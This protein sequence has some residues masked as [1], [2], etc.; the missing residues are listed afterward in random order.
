MSLVKA[1]S[2][3]SFVSEV[4]EE[5]HTSCA[6]L[7]EHVCAMIEEY[8]RRRVE[9]VRCEMRQECDIQI[10]QVEKELAIAVAEK[11]AEVAQRAS[12]S[13]QLAEAADVLPRKDSRARMLNCFLSWRRGVERRREHRLLA[14]EANR[15]RERLVVFHAYSQWRLFAAAR[16]SAHLEAAELHQRDCREEELLGQIDVYRNLLEEEHKKNEIM[17]EKL[18]EA[19]VRGMCALNREAVQALHGSDDEQQD[20]VEAIAAILSR[21]SHSRKL[22]TPRGKAEDY[23]QPGA[24]HCSI[25]PVHQ[26]DQNGYFY[27][28]CFAPGYC[29]YDNHHP[30]SHTPPS[31][32]NVSS[33]PPSP[34]VV[35]ADPRAVRSF[36]AGSS[37]PLR[38]APKPSQTRWKL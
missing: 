35:R 20:D 23:T 18:K 25:C 34:F 6:R 38:H 27:H 19:F 28:R 1:E 33:T 8:L 30:R 16:R 15:H 21:D 12:V 32:S 22:S 5:V 37:V 3:G 26:V 36:N 9:Q 7:N 4:S 24:Q 17:N 29:E 2:D 11:S 13:K 14:E 31:S 10:G